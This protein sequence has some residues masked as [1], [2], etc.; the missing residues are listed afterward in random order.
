MEAKGCWLL[1]GIAW[2]LAFYFLGPDLLRGVSSFSQSRDLKK[3]R[4]VINVLQEG[5]DLLLAGCVPPEAYWNALEQLI[6]PWND[7]VGESL[8]R[9]RWAGAPLIPTFKRLRALAEAQVLAFVSAHA[10]SA[11]ALLQAWMS[12]FAVPVLGIVL[13][14]LLPSVQ[15]LGW[16]WTRA[17]GV[18]FCFTAVAGVWIRSCSHQAR[19]GGLLE[20]ERPWLL[21][22]MCAGERFLAWV[23]SGHPPDLAWSE[24]HLFLKTQAPALAR[25]WGASVW[26]IEEHTRIGLAGVMLSGGASLKKS[27]QVSLMEGIPCIERVEGVL[28][29]L[30]QDIQAAIDRELNLLPTRVLW[31]LFLT[32]FPAVVGLLAYAFFS[33]S[34]GLGLFSEGGFF[35][36]EGI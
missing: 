30:Q 31:P 1:A 32:V 5:E 12:L 33:L 25:G 13:F 14:H 26:Q 8:H 2:G 16:R 22:A 4:Q 7:L 17:C 18:S 9:L 23:R 11:Q 6:P 10:R 29:G 21:T 3:L 19:W 20:E 34:E 15:A 36:L 24:G 27:I 28:L 35:E